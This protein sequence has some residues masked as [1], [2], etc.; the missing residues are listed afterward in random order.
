MAA[1]NWNHTFFWNSLKSQGRLIV[2]FTDSLPSFL[3]HSFTGDCFPLCVFHCFLVIV[4]A[5]GGGG[6]PSGEV[7]D[8]INASFGSFE[9]CMEQLEKTV[10]GHF[11]SGWAWIVQQQ[12]GKLAV[13]DTHDG[14]NPLT[15]QLK[16]LLTC[17]A[18]EHAFSESSLFFV[19]SPP[20]A[21]FP[22]DHSSPFSLC[23]LIRRPLSP[24]FLRYACFFFF[25]LVPPSALIPATTSQPISETSRTSST[26]PL[27]KKTCIVVPLQATAVICNALYLAHSNEFFGLLAIHSLFGCVAFV[28]H[29]FLGLDLTTLSSLLL[30]SLVFFVFQ[31]LEKF[32]LPPWFAWSGLRKT[33]RSI[34]FL[35]REGD[36]QQKTESKES[37]EESSSTQSELREKMV[38]KNDVE[39]RTE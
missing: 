38:V 8:A 14:D 33:K 20:P 5:Q 35:W 16:P 17:D 23:W 24:I 7:L 26:G 4:S 18:W 37:R 32:L 39:D 21:S 22:L 27:F 19:L 12:D 10:V 30:V 1:Q 6:R 15:H 2:S 11:G 3:S 25:F 36:G 34:N 13:I 9:K 29:L 31:F 28:R